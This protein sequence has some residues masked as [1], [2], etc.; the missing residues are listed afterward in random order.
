[1]SPVTHVVKRSGRLVEFDAKRITNAVFKA[2]LS[3][4]GDDMDRAEEVSDSVTKKVQEIYDIDNPPTVE[5]VQDLVVATLRE[6]GHGRTAEAYQRH[7]E[8]HARLRE[9]KESAIVVDDTIPYKILWHVYTWNVEHGCHSVES[10]NEHV[11]RGTMPELIEAAE[12]FYHS[13]IEKL[14]Q[15]ILARR[16]KVRIVIIAGPSSSGKTTTTIKLSEVLKREGIELIAMGLDDYF[17]NLESHPKDEFGDYDFENP[18]ALDLD[19]INRH[20]LT[21][22]RGDSIQMPKYN[23]KTGRREA[24]THEFPLEP[25]Q[26]LLIDSLHGLYGP[27]T[28][29]VPAP[30]K[31]KFY[32]EAL[33][34]VRD[35]KGEFVR[36]A[37]LRMLRRMV[38]DSWH[39]SYSPVKTVGHWHYVRRSEMRHIVPF[40]G[41][42]D[43]VVNGSLAYELT[44]HARRMGPEMEGIVKAYEDQ[45]K[46]YDAL[47]RAQRVRDLLRWVEPLRDEAII[48]SKSLMR[49]YIGGSE[50][51]Y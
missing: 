9:E 12:E 22:M 50:Y 2:A 14:A 13:D 6:M 47:V 39:R 46:R 33:C 5:D 43:H 42:A 24:E 36:W 11:R 49:E 17:K 3:L 32:I 23:F 45:P 16:D 44:V 25:G 27:M 41:K 31:F 20:L 21:L 40:I 18:E 15:R 34:Q 29:S 8:E 4:Q 30:M 19:L 51:K 28:E 26:M 7:R 38:R 48:P 37:D 1:M 10:L 35:T